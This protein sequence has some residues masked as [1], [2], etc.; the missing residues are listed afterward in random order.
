[1]KGGIV[2]NF[3]PTVAVERQNVKSV[4]LDK[5]SVEFDMRGL[6]ARRKCDF[7]GV[8]CSAFAP[9]YL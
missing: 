2:G 6:R 7:S 8:F 9:L 4:K 3:A 5:T 1:M